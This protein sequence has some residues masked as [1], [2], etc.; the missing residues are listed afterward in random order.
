[1]SPPRTSSIPVIQLAT[2]SPVM[3]EQTLFDTAINVLRPKLITIHGVAIP[4]PYGGKQRLVSVDLEIQA[5]Q[6]RGL[7][8]FDAVNA[9]NNDLPIRTSNGATTYLKDVAYVRDGFQPQ[10]NIVRQ[11]GERWNAGKS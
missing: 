10:T 7:G 9:L 11:N 1:M 6:S 2:S 4:F 8:P 3:P 5:L